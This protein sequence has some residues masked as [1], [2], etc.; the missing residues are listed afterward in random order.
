M[1][2]VTTGTLSFPQTKVFHSIFVCQE[3]CLQVAEEHKL[4]LSMEH[5]ADS[6][7]CT[8]AIISHL[9]TISVISEPWKVIFI[10]EFM[11]ILLSFVPRAL[12]KHA[13]SCTSTYL[14]G[15]H[16]QGIITPSIFMALLR[17][18]FLA[19]YCVLKVEIQFIITNCSYS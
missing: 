8:L 14:W 6:T 3:N 16:F 13:S 11:R 4:A 1:I 7:Q 17:L 2:K 19:I 15:E 10:F 5:S 18:Y 9:S 12:L